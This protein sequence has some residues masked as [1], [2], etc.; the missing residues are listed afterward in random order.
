MRFHLAVYENGTEYSTQRNCV[1][2][3]GYEIG[4]EYSTHQKMCD[5]LSGTVGLAVCIC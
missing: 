1:T 2:C 4:T 3:N 5:F